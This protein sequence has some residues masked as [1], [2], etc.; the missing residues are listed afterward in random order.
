M[1]LIALFI[2]LSQVTLSLCAERTVRALPAL[3]MSQ[4]LI[5]G[6]KPS[7]SHSEQL[8][9]TEKEA[10]IYLTRALEQC[11]SEHYI[12]VQIPGLKIEDFQNFT[13]WHNL[14]TRLVG[15]STIFSMP[16]VLAS[17]IDSSPG[18]RFKNTVMHWSSL[19]KVLELHCD[20]VRYTV[21]N[22]DDDEMPKILH[23]DKVL[24]EINAPDFLIHEQQQELREQFLH[25]VD[26]HI[27]NV[28][29]KFPSPKVSVLLAGTTLNDMNR[30]EISNPD[31]VFEQDQ[32]P[33]DP[34][35]LS[36][37]LKESIRVSKRF[38]FPDITVFDK[39][40]YFEY[41]RNKDP[42][43]HLLRDLKDHQWAKDAE[44][45]PGD[46]DDDTWLPKKSKEIV[47][48]KGLYKFGEHEE[49]ES[50]F[51][52]RQFVM[53]NALLITCSALILIVFVSFDLLK[54]LF[55]FTKDSILVKTNKKEKQKTTKKE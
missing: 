43:R 22:L 51:S 32:I 28:C 15:S 2:L 40:R 9:F 25:G 16:N 20:V 12:F 19:T 23:T 29:R 36:A 50:V 7:L 30:R 21:N 37:T 5:P 47:K 54:W 38:I 55:Y 44:K 41:E 4:P 45:D 34:K 3:F 18:A 31:T 39:S 13:V 52:N 49:F 48:E 42:E 46:V 33:A 1:R 53:D 27:R 24:V 35:E 6:L 10:E 14:R 17:N 8:P 26:E 11:T